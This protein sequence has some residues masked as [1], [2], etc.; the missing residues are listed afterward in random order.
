MIITERP[1]RIRTRRRTGKNKEEDAQ[2]D[3]V[4]NEYDV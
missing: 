3:D 2:G 4:E 1:R